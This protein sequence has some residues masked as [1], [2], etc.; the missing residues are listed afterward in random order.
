[1]ANRFR[2]TMALLV[3]VLVH[4]C[5]ALLLFGQAGHPMDVNGKGEAAGASLTVRL[6]SPRAPLP[7][8]NEAVHAKE[9]LA[10][11]EAPEHALPALDSVQGVT[12]P[13]PYY[14]DASV[15]TRPARAFVGLAYGHILVVPGLSRQEVELEVWI[16]DEGNVDRVAVESSLSPAQ[17]Q[18]V[19]AEFAKLRFRPALIGR[20]AVHSRLPMKIIVDSV[21]GV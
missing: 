18:M 10:K 9:Q 7:S 12:H 2:P 21:A 6:L 16:S 19:L 4:G 5:I 15:T 11:T 17:E 14:F 20:I 1:M 13:E 8:V 3:S